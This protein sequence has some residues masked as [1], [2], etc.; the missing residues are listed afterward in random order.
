LAVD[1][2]AN[3]GAAELWVQHTDRLARG[4]GRRADHLIEVYMELRKQDV[5]LRSVHD[6]G[7]CAD[8]IRAVLIGERGQ[9]SEI[10]GGAS[11]EAATL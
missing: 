3:A 6:D 1:A 2:A 7:N 11:G 10:C 9:P 5:S 8:P 4:D